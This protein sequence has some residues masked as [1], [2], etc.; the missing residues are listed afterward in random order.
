MTPQVFTFISRTSSPLLYSVETT[1]RGNAYMSC[2]PPW[3][4]ASNSSGAFHTFR[5]MVT[6]SPSSWASIMCSTGRAGGAVG[7]PT[8]MVTG[9]VA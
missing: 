5:S 3:T 6:F 8:E 7:T 1:V 2:S 4:M 9:S